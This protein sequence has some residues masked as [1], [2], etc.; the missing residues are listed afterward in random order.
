M[1]AQISEGGTPVSFSLN[2]D[3]SNEK[4]P[5]IEMPYVDVP[6]LIQEDQKDKD[7]GIKP[8]RFGYSIDVDID[9]KKDGLK[10][11][12]PNGDNL[13]MLKIH[14][15]NAISVNLIY[16]HFRLGEGSKFFVYNEDKTMV[17]GAFTPEVSNNPTNEF[18]T[19][20]I[21]GST[22]VL[23]YYEPITPDEGIIKISKV[24]H[25]YIDIFGFNSRLLGEAA[26]CNLDANC[27]VS[28][29]GQNWDNEKKAVCLIIMEDGSTGSGCLI[30]NTNQNFTPYILTARHNFFDSNYG[31]IPIRNIG[32]AIFTFHY[33]RPN[34]GSGT[35]ANAQS[36]TGAALIAQD[37][38]TDVLLL[39]LNSKIP[40]SYD[41][42][43]AGWDRST[44]GAT[45]STG[46]HHPNGDAMKISQA[47]STATAVSYIARD[48][49]DNT[50]NHWR[51]TFNDGIVQY[52]SSGSPLF[53][54]NR[55][56]VGQLHGNQNNLCG[57]NTCFCSQIPVGEYGRFDLS[58]TGNNTDSTRL[59]NWLAP[60]S[61]NQP[62]F[63]DGMYEPVI[64][65]S[66]TVC[67][68]GS[69]FVFTSSSVIGTVNW[70]LSA[71]SPFSFNP[72]DQ[73][74]LMQ[75]T[76]SSAPHQVV[77]YRAGTGG[78][79]GTLTGTNS[80][81]GSTSITIS[82]CSLGI[83]GSTTVCYGGDQYTL[84][85][86]PPSSPTL[87]YWTVTGPFSFSSSSTVTSTTAYPPTVYRT[88]GSNSSGTLS[89]RIGSVSGTVVASKALSPCISSIS[90]PTLCYNSGSYSLSNPPPGT[91]YWTVDNNSYSVASSG[92]PVTVTYTGPFSGN[93]ANLSA[94][95]GST[96]GTIIATAPISYCYPTI[97]GPSEVC[98]S[99]SSFSLLNPPP[100]TIYW[101]VD[102]PTMFSI[103]SSGNP[104]VVV[105][106]GSGNGNSKLRARTGSTSGPIITDVVITPCPA[107]AITGLGNICNSGSTVFSINTGQYA[108]WIVTSGFSLST[109]YGISTTVSATTPNQSGTLS[110]VVGG[111]T[112]TR[113][114][115]SLAPPACYFPKTDY[116]YMSGLPGGASVQL[117][118]YP[119]DTDPY[120]IYKWV[121]L[122]EENVWYDVTSGSDSHSVN[123][124]YDLTLPSTLRIDAYQ[125]IAP[126]GYSPLPTV[127][128]RTATVNYRSPI[129][130]FP[131]PV[132]DILNIEITEQ[133]IAKAK[134]FAPTVAG[135]KGGGQDLTFDIR[136]YDVLGN[137]LRNKQ[138]KGGTIQFNV[139]NLPN[140]IY[141]LRIYDGV[142]EKPEMTRIIVNH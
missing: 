16:S 142:S 100:E 1:L 28:V 54:Q 10:K 110:A 38:P 125:Y 78:S 112:Y 9:I 15:S 18:A 126:H 14:S 27:D 39:E 12:L 80:N 127:E 48:W 69:Q 31:S 67:Y 82:P 22:I 63:L 135:S 86:P 89:A 49:T 139:S 87:Y 134:A 47:R 114:I 132:S 113:D 53:N 103:N 11:T 131:N 25:G 20:L 50:P 118:P 106:I 79:S 84:N 44:T 97:S 30:N 55:R 66:N 121:V 83:S 59:S 107:T 111:T 42:Y 92:N 52:G 136:L 99:G 65:G 72:P 138:S 61:S 33:L 37:R 102:D 104:T 17:L 109:S 93:S 119:S 123:V 2:V 7:V 81:G 116:V 68:E 45:T 24:I 71:G 85:Y 76:T 13:W 101:S 8:F 29:L 40:T 36:I 124:L 94:R 21:Q 43:Y 46:L 73:P 34:C 96:S 41:V 90:G 74:A 75:K 108:N 141:F 64:T 120:A 130:V 129:K 51:V 3:I 88:I 23:E 77:V 91:I 57:T 122:F 115:Q 137:Q 19:N 32:T 140:G 35:P 56:I 70:T 133:A 4:I 26:A 58:W 5:V 128:Y 105:R 98:T 117:N 6:S 62:Q 60:G 95:T